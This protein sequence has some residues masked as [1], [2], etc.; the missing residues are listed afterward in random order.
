[1]EATAIFEDRRK[2]LL[3]SIGSSGVALF[4]SGSITSRN[5]DT[6]YPFRPHSDFSYLTG[7]PEADSVAVFAPNYAEGEYIL[8]CRPPD[9]QTAIWDGALIGIE[10][11]CANYGADKAY[12]LH[13]LADR[14]VEICA[15]RLWIHADIEESV[16]RYDLVMGVIIQLRKKARLGIEAPMGV[17]FA[18][19]LLAEQR[20]IKSANELECM[21]TAGQ[22][23]VAAHKHAMRIAQHS[24][25]EYEVQAELE[26][27]MRSQGVQHFAF[28]SIVASGS[29]GCVLHYEQNNGPVTRNQMMVI[30]AGA[31]WQGY[32]ADVTTTFPVGTWSGE[33]RVVYEATLEA[34]RLSCNAVRVG[35]TW[36][37]VHNIAC[38][39]LTQSLIDMGLIKDSLQAALEQSLYQPWFM[40][41]TGHW[42]GR[43]VHDVGDYRQA[44]KWREFVAGMCLTIEP[45]LYIRPQQGV[46]AR[47]WNIGV[48]IE[49]S[50]CVTENG[51]ENLTAGIPRTIKEIQQH[52]A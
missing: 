8:F 2:R 49:D 48:R 18:S 5:R 9:E 13:E 34:H 30:D 32:A 35:Q 28:N 44:N 36:E 10:G 39:S 25:Y 52:L 40:H 23:T 6:V 4:W 38:K 41:R 21:R 11:A 14:L 1:M 50:V 26:L 45:G 51:F 3:H 12:P 22:I 47:W 43:D 46:D 31:E 33:Q 20:L 19:P 37:G 17:C 42:L 15:G 7:F 29:N 16:S 27:V 24:D